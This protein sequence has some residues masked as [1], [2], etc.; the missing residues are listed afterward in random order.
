MLDT[1]KYALREAVACGKPIKEQVP[2]RTCGGLIL[3]QSVPE[4]G[5]PMKRTQA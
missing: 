4:G 5:I 1:S 3:E 2:G